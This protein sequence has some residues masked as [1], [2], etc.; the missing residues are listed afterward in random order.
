[1]YN[2]EYCKCG[3]LILD[4]YNMEYLILI[5]LDNGKVKRFNYGLWGFGLEDIVEALKEIEV[6]NDTIVE[7]IGSNMAKEII[8]A[9][10]E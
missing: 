2:F 3:L 1:M 9:E 7:F 8:L 4:D 6:E 5:N 10:E